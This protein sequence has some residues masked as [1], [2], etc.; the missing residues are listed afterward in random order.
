MNCEIALLRW[1]NSNDTDDQIELLW[2]KPSIGCSHVTRLQE[3]FKRATGASIGFNCVKFKPQTWGL[4]M[5]SQ[6]WTLVLRGAQFTWQRL[7]KT[8]SLKLKCLKSGRY[9]MW[10]VWPHRWVLVTLITLYLETSLNEVM[11]SLLHLLRLRS[12]LHWSIYLNINY[13][14]D[15]DDMTEWR[16]R[17]MN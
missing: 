1:H 6:E 15:L 17:I 10:T 8:T 16:Q 11:D 2:T 14:V 5:M 3:H 13:T 4:M 7:C 9:I 12:R